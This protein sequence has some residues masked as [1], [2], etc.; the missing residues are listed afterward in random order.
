MNFRQ[1]ISI[2]WADID[3]N[4]HLRH[5]AYYDFTAAMRMNILSG[6]GLTTSKLE[7]LQ[8]GPILFRE[9]AVFRREIKLEDNITLDVQLLK[10]FKDYSRFTLRHTFFKEDGTPAATVTVDIAWIDLVKRKLTLPDE[11]MR[12][13]F[14]Q[15]PK[16]PEFEWTEPRAKA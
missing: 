12:N 2:R 3:A 4:R 9:E 7:E 11:F 6:L 5:S 14:A 1:P 8:V 15:F 10:S 13:I 16:G